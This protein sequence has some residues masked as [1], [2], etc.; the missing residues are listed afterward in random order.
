MAAHDM[1]RRQQSR[2]RRHGAALGR[3]PDAGHACPSRALGHPARAIRAD[4]RRPRSSSG[5]RGARSAAG[6]LPR[7]RSP[8]PR[9]RGDLPSPGGRP[10][11]GRR[12]RRGRGAARPGG[13]L[14]PGGRWPATEGRQSHRR[15]DPPGTACQ[16][17]RDGPGAGRAGPSHGRASPYVGRPSHRDRGELGTTSRDPASNPGPTR[18]LDEGS[19]DRCRLPGPLA[20]HRP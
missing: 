15:A 9:R 3:V 18:T 16:R 1:I 11:P 2:G 12:R 7:R 20:H 5:Q 4:R 8:W 19:L 17:P 14:D 10:L 6:R 13:A